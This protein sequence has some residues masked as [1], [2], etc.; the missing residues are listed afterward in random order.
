[1]TDLC[2]I[3]EKYGS[4]KV[5]SLRHNYTKL[6]H[7]LFNSMRDQPLRVFELGIGTVDP[8]LVSNMSCYNGYKPG[9]S[10]RGWKEYFPNSQIYGADIDTNILFEEDRI[11]T[12]F[13]DQ[14]KPEVIKA[15]WSQ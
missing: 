13:C 1:M 6:Y 8:K 11:E 3:M 9:A 5:P 10:L 4:D 2:F 7:N 14:T 15:L 12:F